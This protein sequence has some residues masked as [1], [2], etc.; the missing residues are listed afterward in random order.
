V[1]HKGFEV[2]CVVKPIDAGFDLIVQ[3]RELECLYMSLHPHRQIAKINILNIHEN[4]CPLKDDMPSKGAFLLGLAEELCRQV[5]IR[6]VSLDDSSY[7]TTREGVS[8]DLQFLSV[9]RHGSSWFERRGYTPT[10]VVEGGRAEAIAAA[11]FASVSAVCA[12]IGKLGPAE[13]AATKARWAAEYRA[14]VLSDSPDVKGRLRVSSFANADTRYDEFFAQLASRAALLSEYVEKYKKARESDRLCDF[15][16]FVWTE[17]SASY[18][19]IA[20]LLFPSLALKA[21]YNDNKRQLF[22]PSI[23]PPFPHCSSMTKSVAL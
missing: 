12:F 21:G 13:E 22:P 7:V 8:V 5:G 18:V 19:A 1:V 20:S 16:G 17:S 23:L 2:P 9:M 4:A 15:L 14:C 10:C 6:T 3:G 11:R